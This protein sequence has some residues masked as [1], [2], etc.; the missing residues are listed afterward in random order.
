MPRRQIPHALI[1]AIGQ[2]IQKLRKDAGLTQE[3][4][5]YES[6]VGSKGYLSDIENGKRMATLATLAAIAD[7]L[8]VEVVDLLTFPETGGP[9]HQVIDRLRKLNNAQRLRVAEAIGGL[10]AKP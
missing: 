8:G 6:E 1:F 10:G 7:H 9:K 4:L 3:K 5:A 2:R